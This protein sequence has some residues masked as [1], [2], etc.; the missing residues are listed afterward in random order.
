MI[1]K[2]CIVMF[3]GGLDS[4]LVLKIMQKKGYDVTALYFKLPFSRNIE[5]EIKKFCKK[6]K[7]KLKVFDYTKGNL[8]KSYLRM[9]KK[10][11]FGR[12]TGINPCIDCRLFM[13]SKTKKY[14]DKN[15][16]NVIAS[17]EVLGQRPMSQHKKA[18]EITEKES[19]LSKR[20]VRPLI[21]K[22]IRG[23]SRKKQIQLAKE[24]KITYPNPAGGCL[25]CEKG[26]KTRFRFLINRGINK[27]EL[28]LV[29]IGRHFIN[30]K[31][32]MV[33]GRNEKENSIIEKTK[34]IKILPKQP[35]PSAWINDK[36]LISK[37]KKLIKKYSKHK[38]KEFEIK[39]K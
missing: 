3:S 6:Q 29:G 9:L 30:S 33:L 34:G 14:A 15:K 7:A 1:K 21:E 11:R 10:P 20:L 24:F 4:R 35:G 19:K 28:K 25:L 31:R 8:L 36:K 17:G 18:L 13:F 23:R 12:G 26:L 16:I 32:W 37:A 22:G 2:K 39:L 27:E 5:D 38:I